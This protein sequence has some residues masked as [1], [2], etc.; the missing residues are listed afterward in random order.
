MKQLPKTLDRQISLFLSIL[1]GGMWIWSSYDKLLDIEGFYFTLANYR[2]FPDLLQGMIALT[3][4]VFEL[5]LGLMLL[6]RINLK[7]G[8]VI[9][10]FMMILF[11]LLLSTTWL[12]GIDL[13]CGCFSLD[14][15]KSNLPFRIVADFAIMIL[16]WFG[17]RAEN[18]QI[19]GGENEY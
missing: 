4:P 2:L 13:N 15:K 6:F 9:T 1:L 16:A 18:K 12:R 10:G 14:E 3:V 17:I 19:S 11:I 7:S 8:Y 5:A